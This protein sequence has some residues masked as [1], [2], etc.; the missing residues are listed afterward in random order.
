M[1]YLKATN[2]NAVLTTF[3]VLISVSTRLRRKI[4]G[5]RLSKGGGLLKPLEL[6]QSQ[7]ACCRRGRLW[8]HP[9]RDG[10][11]SKSLSHPCAGFPLVGRQHAAH[12]ATGVRSSHGAHSRRQ[13]SRRV[14]QRLPIRLLPWHPQLARRGPFQ[15]AWQRSLDRC[16]RCCCCCFAFLLHFEQGRRRARPRSSWKTCFHAIA[17]GAKTCGRWFGLLLLK[18][19]LLRQRARTPSSPLLLLPPWRARRRKAQ[20]CQ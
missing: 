4:V 9:P 20:R 13:P 16:R 5:S 8:R 6:P 3:S 17:E 1:T 10:A 11:W 18:L 12:P 7:G 15:R 2:Q 14:R 19:L